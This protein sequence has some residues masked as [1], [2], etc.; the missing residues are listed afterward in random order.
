T[1]LEQ[2]GV[3]LQLFNYRLCD[4]AA[5]ADLECKAQRVARLSTQPLYIL[6]EA[7]R[8]LDNERV[9]APGYTF[10]QDL[11]GRVVAGERQRVTQLLAQA[12]TSGLED[13]LEALLQAD[14]G[15]YRIS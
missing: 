12:L 11:V 14:Q 10:L 7:L 8:Y 5:K 2:Q 13:Q 15:M 3:I 1:R 6:R 4:G 9:V